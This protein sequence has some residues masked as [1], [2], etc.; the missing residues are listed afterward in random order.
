VTLPDKIRRLERLKNIFPLF[1]LERQASLIGRSFDD[2]IAHA[3][4]RG[5]IEEAASLG[6][7]REFELQEYRDQILTIRTKKLLA[8]ARE[9]YI[10]F[11][12]LKWERGVYGWSYLE[13]ES[14]SKVYH[15]VREERYKRA[16]FRLKLIGALTGIIG[17]LIGL[18]A[19][20]KR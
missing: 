7:T 6:Q 9:L 1:T 18:A 14:L 17:A 15:A 8:K 3:T 19:V 5:D 20:L 2:E 10:L 16:E 4:S 13:S 12:D 11:S